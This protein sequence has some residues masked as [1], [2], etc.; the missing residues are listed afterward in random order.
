MHIQVMLSQYLSLVI[1]GKI[2]II[3]Q[4]VAAYPL[5]ATCYVSLW[6]LTLTVVR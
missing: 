1:S 5:Q 4:I 6:R 3:T 2:R